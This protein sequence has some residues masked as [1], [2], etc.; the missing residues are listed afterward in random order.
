MLRLGP[1]E[2][3]GRWRIITI[4]DRK[5]G[6]VRA[7]ASRGHESVCFRAPSFATNRVSLFGGAIS[8][9]H[10]AGSA[11]HKLLDSTQHH[12]PLADHAAPVWPIC[13]RNIVA[14]PRSN[15]LMKRRRGAAT[16]NQAGCCTRP[17]VA[18]AWAQH[19]GHT[20]LVAE[21]AVCVGAFYSLRNLRETH[22]DGLESVP[23]GDPRACGCVGCCSDGDASAT[24]D[25][26][27]SFPL[28][29][30]LAIAHC[31]SPPTPSIFEHAGLRLHASLRGH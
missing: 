22:T 4:S 18:V 6:M 21:A 17:R 7:R 10:N 9:I 12:A 14:T 30:R 8:K 19:R 5:T 26:A 28:L 24:S 15:N 23:R 31:T 27:S 25:Y 20:V 2:L 13:V 16:A 29:R 11:N 3:L 1:R